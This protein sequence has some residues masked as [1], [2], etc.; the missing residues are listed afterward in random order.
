MV[1]RAARVAEDVL[2]LGV[3]GCVHSVFETAMNLRG[4][5]GALRTVL[6]AGRSLSPRSAVL[7]SEVSFTRLGF[8]S[9]DAVAVEIAGAETVSLAMSAMRPRF[10]SEDAA[11]LGRLRVLAAQVGASAYAAES[12]APV[13]CHLFDGLPYALSHNVYSRFLTER[14]RRLY[15]VLCARNVS[16]CVDVGRTLAGCGAGLTPSSDDLLVG[17]LAAIHGSAAAGVLDRGLAV[18]M[19]WKLSLGAVSATT[20]ISGM[21]L[22][23]GGLGY[24]NEDVIALV[25]AFFAAD[26][27]ADLAVSAAK[28]CAFGAT[29]GVDLLTG[30]WLGLVG[31][32][33][34]VV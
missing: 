27:T 32:G 33:G 17:V 34:L 7:D 6:S 12:L 28:V 14:V 24:F 2:P 21:F 10:G 4:D 8:V 11:Y 18:D 22:E 15:G 16:E 29:S 31:V 5:D 13:L 30:V 19:A 23:S 9:G 20:E 26:D 1:L 25:K 3:S